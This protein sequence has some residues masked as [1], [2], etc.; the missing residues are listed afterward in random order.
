MRY[1]A[2]PTYDEMA[3]SNKSTEISAQ[4]LCAG[5]VSENDTRGGR[6]LYISATDT[7]R[8]KRLAKLLLLSCYCV[9]QSRAALYEIF[10]HSVQLFLGDL[11]FAGCMLAHNLFSSILT[12]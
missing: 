1:I 5:M 4:K 8:Y 2:T 3:Q 11:I 6:A 9:L 7:V 10:L 12:I